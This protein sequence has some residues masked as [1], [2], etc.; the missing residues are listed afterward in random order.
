MQFTLPSNLA[1]EDQYTGFRGAIMQSMEWDKLARGSI[2]QGALTNSK[3]PESF[4]K[5]VYPTHLVSGIGP[6]LIDT[7]NKRYIDFICGLGTCIYGYNNPILSEFAIRGEKI[8]C[9]LSLS[10]I[11]EIKA[12]EKVKEFMP[13]IERLRFLKTGSE[14]CTAAIT[15]AR[16]FTGRNL[17]FS[18]GYHGWNPEFTSLTP[19]ANG[20]PKWPT[21]SLLETS[22]DLSNAAAVIIEPVITDYSDKRKEQL[23]KLREECTKHGVI[24]I[25]D[26]TIT[27]LRFP[28]LSVASYFGIT[29]DLMVFGKAL[30]GGSSLACVGGRGDVMDCDYFVSSTF[31][32]EVGPLLKAAHIMEKI[33]MHQPIQRLWDFGLNFWEQFN[34][35]FDGI[36]KFEGYPTRG[37]L[38]G[39]EVPK[40]LFM[41]EACKAGLL[42]GASPFLM[43]P[44]IELKEQILSV[45]KDVAMKLRTQN[46]KLEGELP[47]KPFAQKVREDNN[48]KQK[49][50][51]N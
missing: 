45:L 46:V 23:L 9:T 6:Y 11:H 17:V 1:V 41:Q 7:N 22:I 40:A 33:K 25:F 49:T 32:G 34:M 20:C 14:A 50:H 31:A 48:V 18:D 44:H 16:A 38:K 15:I 10:S 12:A 26:E 4:I 37:I 21:I 19:P 47:K 35:I 43:F 30:G 51:N 27:A 5:G 42:F 36:V 29:P 13:Q 2:S 39:E 28:G 8:G 24:L 3:R